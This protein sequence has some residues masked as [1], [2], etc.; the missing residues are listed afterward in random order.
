MPHFT[1]SVDQNGLLA[2]AATVGVSQPRGIA[3]LTSNLPVP[4]PIPITAI[5]D[6]GAT[7]TCLDRATINALGISATGSATAT[8]PSTGN[9]PHTF[10]VFDIAISIPSRVN[11]LP[12]YRG[13]IPVLCMDQPLLPGVQMLLGIDILS[14][15]TLFVDGATGIFSLAY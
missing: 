9:T 6:T 12:F 13:T 5:V 10:E 2:L 15:C 11:Q 4:Q 3:L 7:H 8:T 14:N 1:I